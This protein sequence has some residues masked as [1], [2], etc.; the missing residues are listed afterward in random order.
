MS[1]AAEISAYLFA[2]GETPVAD[3]AR[4]LGASLATIRR[5]LAHLESS[6]LVER[7]HGAARLA[8]AAKAEVGHKAREDRNLPAKRAIARLAH[9]LLRPGNTILLDAGTT[10]L[11]LA[12]QI[13]LAPMPLTVVTN[14]LAVA[15]ELADL[16]QVQLCILGGR[17][18][19]GH[20]SLVG[21][22]AETMLA[23][24]WLDHAFVGASAVAADGW[25]TSVDADEARLNAA[26]ADR[27]TRLT[28]L[29][30]RS[31]LGVRATFAVRQLTGAETLITDQPPAE[32]VDFAARTGLTLLH[33]PEAADG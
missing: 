11:Q 6:G 18:R 30:D 2:Q 10:V 32:F 1:R 13:R 26:M 25:I 9:G 4:V 15:Q 31:K 8:Q 33:P 5:D 3:L 14:G 20:L 27:A 21:P 12:R 19:P 28:L 24:L 29:A 16:P 7:L 17:L 22:L 23:G